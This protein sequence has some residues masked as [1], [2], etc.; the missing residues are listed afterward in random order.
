MTG[1]ER[2]HAAIHFQPV[3]KAPLQYK[4]SDVGYYEHG[5]KLND[6][7]A[8]LP[9]DF[10][11]FERKPI[12]GPRPDQ[13]DENGRFHAFETD[14]W[15]VEWEKR[16]YGV[17]GIPSR[18]P[19][20]EPEALS[21]YQPPRPPVPGSPE[22]DALKAHY[23][24]RNAGGYYTMHHCGGI[25]ERLIALCGDENVL[26]G[27]MLEDAHIERVADMITENARKHAEAAVLL[28]VD[29]VEMGDDYGAERSL[30]MSP[31]MW[32]RFFKP[33]LKYILEPAVR[34]G[35]DIHF[36]SCGM[37]AD[38]LEDFKD[39]GITSIWPQL[40]AFNMEELA[41]R[42]RELELAVAIHTD[43]ANTMTFGTPRQVRDLVKREYDVFRMGDGGSWFF[44]EMD[45]GFPFQNVQAQI[46]T[47]AQWR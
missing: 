46:E 47:I 34:A 20:A 1:K 45:N 13:I 8:T 18:N 40:P 23:A 5:E 44:V 28:G 7:F 11:P 9:G 26:C 39:L 30:L 14:E 10:E 6:L 15:G 38:I 16:I 42:C 37:I 32:R 21:S 31:A 19:L 2:V 36:H 43:R 33:R 24:A 27:I 29:A 17:A 4:Y 41:K 12:V 3:D 22:F 35:M 25:Y